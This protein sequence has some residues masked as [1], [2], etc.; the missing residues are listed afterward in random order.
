MAKKEFAFRGKT[1]DELKKLSINEFAQLIA[2]RERRSL[3]RGLTD[4]EKK[5]YARLKVSDKVKTHCRTMVVLPEMVG[6]TIEIHKGNTFEPIV[7]LEEMV[8]H[9]LGEFALTRKKVT[10]GAPG[11][12]ASKSSKGTTKT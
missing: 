4:A 2:S 9:R 12:G 10:H 5:L 3:L 6:K 1:L 8:G 7:I 11:L